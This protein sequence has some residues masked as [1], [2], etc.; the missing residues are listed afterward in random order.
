V[1]W[2]DSHADALAPALRQ[3]ANTE[4]YNFIEMTKAGCLPLK[5]AV[6]YDWGHPV[7]AGT[8]MHY[9]D[10]VL[11][12][13]AADHR[14][15]IVIIAGRWEAPFFE[16]NTNPL[17]T[18]LAHERD[19]PS[20]ESV[21]STFVKS[22]SAA[23][24]SLQRVD[25]HVIVIDDVPNFEF[26]PLCKVRTAAIPARRTMAALLGLDT[27]SHGVAPRGFVSASNQSTNLL[28]QIRE[29]NRGVELIDLESSLCNSQNLCAYMDG[30]RLLYS[31]A[32]HLT[33][34]GAR[35][36]LRSFLLPH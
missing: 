7:V 18:D 4:G 33:A 19:R 36:A 11:N 8:C 25:K 27:D 24:Q 14:I 2:G 29:A 28:R 32:D 6:S 1:L 20:P 9:N 16:G 30:G 13:I 15:R 5:G 21:P 22:L 31:D 12:L 35:Y 17:I 3:I 10:E 26:D 23:I 34:D